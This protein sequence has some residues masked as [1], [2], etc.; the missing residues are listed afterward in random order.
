MTEDRELLQRVLFS[1]MI[2]LRATAYGITIG[3]MLGGLLF[4]VTN[5]LIL[6]GGPIGPDGEPVI[7]PHLQLLGHILIGYEVTFAGS[8]VGFAYGFGGGFVAGY[9][10]AWIYNGLVDLKIRKRQQAEERTGEGVE[11]RTATEI[12]P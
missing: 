3:L 7:G 9:L 1:R 2:R 11:Q 6:K 10:M 5:W 4:L 8:L 12:Q